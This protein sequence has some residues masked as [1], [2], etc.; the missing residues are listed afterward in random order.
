MEDT[1]LEYGFEEEPKIEKIYT[2]TLLDGTVI[3]NLKLNGNNFVSK[4]EITPEIFDGNLGTV[5]ISD[6]KTVEE[7]TNM[8]L[9][10][11]TKM[12]EEWWFVLRDIPKKEIEDAKLRSDVDFIAMMTDVEL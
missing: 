8:N 1:I 9:V 4:S 2:I 6:G 11:V 7:H 12:G 10:Q 3:E 5:Q